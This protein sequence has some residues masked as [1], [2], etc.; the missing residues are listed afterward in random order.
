MMGKIKLAFYSIIHPFAGFEEIKWHKKGSILC[1]TIFLLFYYLSSIVEFQFTGFLFT[2][3]KPEDLNILLLAVSNLIPF[4]LFSVSNW[5]VC[6]LFDGEGRFAEIYVA[7]GY[8]LVPYTVV[9]FLTTLLSNF[10]IRDEYAFVSMLSTVGLIWSLAIGFI[11]LNT[12][13]QYTF[14]K[15]FLSVLASLLGVFIILFLCV[16]A[17]SLWNQVYSFIMSIYTEIT[18]RT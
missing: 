11:G 10:V 13:H 8:A 3:N 17:G 7:V 9:R 2:T 6:T 4:V 18:F 12:V 15:T 5:A 16:L 1:A 14:K